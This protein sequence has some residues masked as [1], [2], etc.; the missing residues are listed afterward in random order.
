MYLNTIE[1]NK[2]IM[3]QSRRINATRNAI[4]GMMSKIILMAFPFIIKS[5][6][7]RKLGAEYLG[8]DS[9]FVSI[10]QVLNLAELGFSSAVTFCLYKPLAENDVELVCA[11]LN[12]FKKV[13]K[14]IGTIIFLLG[15]VLMPFVP[16]IIKSGWPEETNIYILYVLQLINTTISYWLWAYKNVLLEASQ[17]QSIIN[18][19]NFGTSFL[20]YIFQ[21]LA[22][23]IFK[24]YYLYLIILICSTVINNIYVNI[25]TKRLF[26]EYLYK[27]ELDIK[28]K[29][30][31][32]K[33]VSGVAI[34]K[35]ATT[36]RNSFD[37]IFLSLY[38]GLISVSI[39]SNYYYIFSTVFAF[40]VVLINAVAAGLGDY[41]ARE[42]AEANYKLFRNLDFAVC[43]LGSWIT[44]CMICLYQDAMKVWVGEKY[45]APTSTM[46]LFCIYYY[47]NHIGVLRSTY[48]RAY[49]IWWQIKHISI[50]EA[51]SNIIL[52]AVLGYLYGMN[53]IILATIITVFA[54]SFLWNGKVVINKCFMT[55]S[56]EYFIRMVW[57]AMK[58]ICS[59]IVTILVCEH[60]NYNNI[61]LG[62]ILKLC[63]CLVCPN[64]IFGFLSLASRTDRSCLKYLK[65]NIRLFNKKEN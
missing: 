37:S 62:I 21:I 26:P 59:A 50:L 35:V 42:S 45:L 36:C 2:K 4:T 44:I 33:Q 16:M 10:L 24:N 51:V 6:I 49:G 52:N 23:I 7:I 14:W 20:R 55:S 56:K 22:I 12:F 57:N 18:I 25:A 15:I 41:A 28:S 38:L 40:V 65:L 48:S 34:S 58:T 30:E 32:Q 47:V 11:Y 60:I 31:L 8:L 19:I 46:I 53:G 39:Y 43:W 3:N 9:L 54:F 27:V 64:V 29:K 13:Y 1:E 61:L 5:I 63:I 17:K